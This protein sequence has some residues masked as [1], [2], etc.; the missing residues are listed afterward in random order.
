MCMQNVYVYLWVNIRLL[1]GVYITFH[2]IDMFHLKCL[3]YD[4]T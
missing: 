1:H 4:Q 3:T 2:G